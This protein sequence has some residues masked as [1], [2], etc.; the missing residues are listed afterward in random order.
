MY[1]SRFFQ[2]ILYFS[3]SLLLI[4]KSRI[5]PSDFYFIYAVLNSYLTFITKPY[6]YRHKN[7]I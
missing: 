6:I 3:I 2:P 4:E 1:T 5:N 7:R